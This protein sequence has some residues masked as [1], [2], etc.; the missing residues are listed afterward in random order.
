MKVLALVN[1]G[2]AF[3]GLMLAS[4]LFSRRDAFRWASR[5]LGALVASGSVI[6]AVMV[7]YQTGWIRDY[8]ALVGV[9]TPLVMLLGPLFWFYLLHAVRPERGLRAYDVLHAT[10]F[11]IYVVLL[12][13]IFTAPDAIKLGPVLDAFYQDT[14]RYQRAQAMHI[15]V[16]LGHSGAYFLAGAWLL[17]RG[18]GL[19]APERRGMRLPVIGIGLIWGVMCSRFLMDLLGG[20]VTAESA[21]LMPTAISALLCVMGWH[22]LTRTADWAVP[23]LPGYQQSGLTVDQA[24]LIAEEVRALLQSDLSVLDPQFDLARL[25]ELS[26]YTRHQ[27]SEALNRGGGQSF[28]DLVNEVRCRHAYRLL[29]ENPQ[30]SL[31]DLAVAAGFGARSTFYSAF[32]RTFGAA[33]GAIKRQLL[34]NP[35]GPDSARVKLG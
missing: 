7:L 35:A 6:I 34:S 19:S 3:L 12:W 20:W 10:P 31:E 29:T 14:T 32:R 30:Q 4:A 2:S 16:T 28:R 21:M 23:K 18:A 8:P 25:A 22:G 11:L 26:G 1:L 24:G 27:L 15:L 5:S 9:Q 33:P 13:P 17:L